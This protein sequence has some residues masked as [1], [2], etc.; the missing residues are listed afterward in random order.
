MCR[1]TAA[2][3]PHMPDNGLLG[4]RAGGSQKPRPECAYRG[5]FLQARPGLGLVHTN[6]HKPHLTRASFIQG[7]TRSF[8]NAQHLGGMSPA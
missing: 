3:S 7:E 5:P 6:S 2:P 4:G 8:P 1:T